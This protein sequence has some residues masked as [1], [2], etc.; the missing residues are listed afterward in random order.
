M[1][2]L[3]LL[4]LAAAGVAG[5]AVFVADSNDSAATLAAFGQSYDITTL[6][7]FLLGTVVGIV[8]IVGVS[9]MVA[10][11]QVRRDRRRSLKAENKA[12]RARVK[13]ATVVDAGDPYPSEQTASSSHALKD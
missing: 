2:P 12:L 9:L 5:A 8:G 10:G 7:V 11:A 1:L 6:G 13:D 4:L 3:G